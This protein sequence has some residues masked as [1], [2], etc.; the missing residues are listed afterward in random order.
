M[1]SRMMKKIEEGDMPIWWAILIIAIYA[2]IV[3]GI[4]FLTYFQQEAPSF[5][6]EQFTDKN[7]ANKV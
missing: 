5:R 1:S 7:V 2:T 3:I 6:W 4:L